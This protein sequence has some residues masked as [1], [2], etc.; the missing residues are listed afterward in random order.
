MIII[1]AVDIKDGKCVRLLQ[2][3][4]EDETV[5]SD[6]PW[7]MALRWQEAGARLLH[8]VD[9]NGAFEGFGVNDDAVRAIVEHVDMDAELGGGIRDMARI[10]TLLDMGISRVILGTVAVENPGLVKAAIYKYGPEKIVVGIDATN[11]IAKTRGW[12]ED[13]G[14]PAVELGL[15]MKK[16]GVT[17]I[18]YTDISRDGMLTGPNI[19]ETE[20]M[21][22]ETG[23]KLVA[24]GG[25]SSLDDIWA[26]K[27]I[28]KYGVDSVITGKAIYEGKFD[29]REAIEIA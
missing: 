24:S 22:R 18:I 10:D 6:T 1:P 7:K 15:D 9:L 29:L 3:R 12:A 23:L 17:R 27:S 19:A 21:A 28:E 8:I 25:V 14:R 16:L 5:Y 13:G 2:G 4:M 11:G 20:R 26:L